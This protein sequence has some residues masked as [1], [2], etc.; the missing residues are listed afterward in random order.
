MKRI[1]FAGT[2]WFAALLMA[3]LLPKSGHGQ[4]TPHLF[5]DAGRVPEMRTQ[6]V[7]P[8]VV[9]QRYTNI[10]FDILI[11]P[12]A[13]KKGRSVSVSGQRAVYENKEGEER[14]PQVDETPS[15]PARLVMDLFNDALYTVILERVE[16]NSPDGKTLTWWGHI[17]EVQGGRVI[18][19]ST[20][21]IMSGNIRLPDGTFYQIRYAGEDLHVIREIDQ[22]AF[23]PEAP[24]VSPGPVPPGSFDSGGGEGDL[25][26]SGDVEGD[27]FSTQDESGSTIDVMVVYT[28]AARMAVG[29]TAAMETLIL[30]AVNETNDGYTNS[31][32]VQRI[33]LVHS[34]EVDYDE[35]DTHS[36]YTDP[37]DIA[38]S[39]LKGKSDGRMDG[40]HTLRDDYGA[41]MVSLYIDDGTWCGMAYVMY[42]E[43]HDFEE[44]A[45]SVIYHDCATGYFSFA[46]EMGHN[47]GAK[48]DR[49]HSPGD[50]VFSYSHGY[51]DPEEDFRTIMSYDCPSGCDRVNHW[52]NPEV[53]YVVGGV[54]YGTTG[55]VW[56]DPDSADMRRSHNNTRDTVANWRP[57]YIYVDQDWTGS[58]D[59]L[60]ATPFDTLR[61][62][63]DK[64]AKYGKETRLYLKP[65]TYTGTGSTPITITKPME[66]RVWGTGGI[67][68]R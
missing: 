53:D 11:S 12:S 68:I 22:R 27:G 4:A 9:R 41:D 51:Q 62:G 26:P 38:L 66:I 67:T 16:N 28:E 25:L 15:I 63:V 3:A 19:V 29:G 61:E 31:G 34:E 42:N 14:E 20:D 39:Y 8:T 24:P 2:W 56:D 45:F 43:S 57:R 60:S 37:Y 59:G 32:I 50:G 23:P 52:S 13:L 48:H 49:Q 64:M 17:A 35:N 46:H 1:R 21:G 55:V 5:R 47:Q 65:D 54:N 10:A 40:V 30:L 18:L 7:P 6:S 36:S 58:E 44:S 33:N